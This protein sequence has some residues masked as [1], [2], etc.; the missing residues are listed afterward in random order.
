MFPPFTLYTPLNSV[1][2][3][4]ET[5]DAGYEATTVVSKVLF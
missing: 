1:E 5:I 2:H 3:E 4:V